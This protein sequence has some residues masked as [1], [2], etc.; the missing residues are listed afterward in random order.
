LRPSSHV[1]SRMMHSVEK[2]LLLAICLYQDSRFPLSN[3]AEN[4]YT[5]L[6]QKS[7]PTQMFL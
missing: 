6:S 5:R 2:S 1:S 7:F 3:G 4:P